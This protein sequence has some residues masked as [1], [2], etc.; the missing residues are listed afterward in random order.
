M[1]AKPLPD[2]ASLLDEHARLTE[3]L[4]RLSVAVDSLGHAAALQAGRDAA[5]EADVAEAE[6]LAMLAYVALCG[7]KREVAAE[8]RAACEAREAAGGAR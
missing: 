7:R 2:I 1:T 3:T 8:I 6:R 5:V 4:T